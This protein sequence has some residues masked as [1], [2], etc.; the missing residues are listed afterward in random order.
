M[1]SLKQPNYSFIN[2]LFNQDAHSLSFSG[3]DTDADAAR[4][5]FS[6][7]P[8]AASRDNVSYTSSFQFD[9]YDIDKDNASEV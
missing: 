7:L 2:S 3:G 9:I 8:L 1:I 6:P 4:L 5:F